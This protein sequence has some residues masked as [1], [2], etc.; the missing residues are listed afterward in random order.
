MSVLVV[1]T[2]LPVSAEELLGC[3]G[4]LLLSKTKCSKVRFKV[5]G[6]TKEVASLTYS[7]WLSGDWSKKP[8]LGLRALR[9]TNWV[10]PSLL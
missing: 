7:K 2:S 8:W 9:N 10:V 4:C 3:C 5:S 6:N 1:L